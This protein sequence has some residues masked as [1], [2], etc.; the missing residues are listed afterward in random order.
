MEKKDSIRLS[1]IAR[2]SLSID[3][4]AKITMKSLEKI[5]NGIIEETKN[6]EEEE[7]AVINIKEEDIPILSNFFNSNKIDVYVDRKRVIFDKD[8]IEYAQSEDE[9]K[10]SLKQLRKFGKNSI[11][12]NKKKQLQFTQ[13]E[14]SKMSNEFILKLI[15]WN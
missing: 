14:F 4:K 15:K 6:Y 3:R 2:N 9:I 10:I 5:C 1:N 12:K 7:V 11:V 13:E 8:F